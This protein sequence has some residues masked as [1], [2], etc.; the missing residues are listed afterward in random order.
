MD[1][2]NPGSSQGDGDNRCSTP[3]LLSVLPE[4]NA[5]ERGDTPSPS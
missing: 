5:S 1:D 4:K 3:E 2:C